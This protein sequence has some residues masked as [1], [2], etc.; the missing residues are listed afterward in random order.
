MA[1]RLV[2]GNKNTSSWSLRPWIAMRHFGIA[3]DEINI[4]LR[5]PDAKALILSHSPSGKVP[6]LLAGDMVIW[7][8]LAILEFLA[9]THPDKELWPQD[10][11]ARSLARS[12]AAEM[13]S[14]FPTLREECPMDIVARTPRAKLSSQA[15]ADVR[16][17]VAVWGDCRR[18]F[19]SGG[20]FLFG[21]F[22]A[23]DAMYA[24]VATRF[25]TYL[26]GLAAFGDDGASQA[27]ADAIFALP[28]FKAWEAQASREAA[29]A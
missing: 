13:H 21:R 28:A 22:S 11:A 12:V 8:S 5:A 7:D 19:A 26:S 1:Y 16:R 29:P 18:R 6:A 20:P 4:D 17:I 10:K 2:I 25:R 15:E 24:P 23:A 3:F 27:Y 9:E 14:G